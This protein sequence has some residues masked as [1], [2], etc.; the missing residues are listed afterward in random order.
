M[1]TEIWKPVAGYEWLY[2]ISNIWNVRSNK[3]HWTKKSRNLLPDISKWY[4]RVTLCNKWIQEKFLVHRLVLITFTENIENKPEVNHI[5]GDKL[6]NHVENLEWA[7]RSENQ[8]HRFDVL[9]H[10]QVNEKVVIQYL[11]DWS[12]K[13][14]RSTI[15]A[16][17]LTWCRHES[18][19]DVCRGRR[20]RTWWYRWSYQ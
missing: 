11:H 9:W 17:R 6:N 18:I 15:E 20:K 13:K 2:D 10:R 1:D 8:K 12:T 3:F 7:T 14:F 4:F 19:A 5:D 16:W